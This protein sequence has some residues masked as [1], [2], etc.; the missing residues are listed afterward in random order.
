MISVCF[1]WGAAALVFFKKVNVI[2]NEVQ[3]QL[4]ISMCAYRRVF[5]T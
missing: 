4:V 5:L 3:I 1:A 2:S